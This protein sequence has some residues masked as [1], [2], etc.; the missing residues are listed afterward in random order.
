V[1][2]VQTNWEIL[3]ETVWQI[4]VVAAAQY[5]VVGMFRAMVD[6]VS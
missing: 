4:P 1:A 6:L 2:V 5:M 3:Q